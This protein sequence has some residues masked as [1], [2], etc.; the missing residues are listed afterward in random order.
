MTKSI[1]LIQYS[2][3]MDDRLMHHLSFTRVWDESRI[4]FEVHNYY[5]VFSYFFATKFSIFT[6]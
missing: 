2:N 6:T 3:C 4:L 5:I 1:Q